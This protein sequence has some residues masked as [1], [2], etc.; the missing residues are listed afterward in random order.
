[1]PTI[2]EQCRTKGFLA[3]I[4]KRGRVMVTDTGETVAVLV[5]NATAI[6][7]ENKPVQAKHP[8]YAVI[9]CLAGALKNPRAV[10]EFIEG[11]AP[12]TTTHNVLSYNETSGDRV[13]WKFEVESQRQTFDG[14]TNTGGGE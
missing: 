11:A 5:E 6:P 9:T 14:T 10:Q 3:N 12:N 7:D 1:M 8:V 13:T 4:A 2:T